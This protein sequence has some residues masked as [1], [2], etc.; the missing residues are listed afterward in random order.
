MNG[1]RIAKWA[2]VGAA[3]FLLAF[4]VWSYG[5]AVGKNRLPPAG[6][7][8]DAI[9]Y[10]RSYATYGE[11]VPEK[12]RVPAPADAPRM[13]F[14]L[15]EPAAAMGIGYY[16]ILGWDDAAGRYAVWLHEADGS[17]AHVWPVDETQFAGLPRNTS[18]GPHAML[19]LEDGSVLVSF[20]RKGIM[21]RL[22][23]CGRATWMKEGFYHHSFDRA[24]DGGVWTWFGAGT[25]YGHYQY[26]VKFDP[27][28]G[29]VTERI[30]L[31]EDIIGEDP[32][33]RALF[34][35]APNY[36][37]VPDDE[38]PE[39]FLH[40]NDVEELTAALAPAFPMFAPGDL[41]LSIRNL[42]MVAVIGRDGELKW[43][44]QGP[45]REQH[46]PDF[47]PDGTIA[48]FNNNVDRPTSNV[49]LVDPATGAITNASGAFS[50]FTERRGKQ[51]TLPNGNILITIP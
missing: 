26:V 10:V 29:A 50:F 21:A 16:A 33:R 32:H 41:M 37:F 14:A 18:T 25:A 20:D 19:P 22:D 5:V 40:T 1:D 24:S 15:H 6:L 12:R 46:D 36:R 2:F 51:E 3:G 30:G 28:T 17:L 38:G 11:F 9:R 47:R 23:A 39:D 48:V 4:A 44:R 45:W 13:R 31:V 34:S 27:D 8:N 42:H 7:V 43:Y 49:L 35:V